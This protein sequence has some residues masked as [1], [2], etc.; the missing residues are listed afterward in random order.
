VA[1]G[2]QFPEAR[3]VRAWL[4]GGWHVALACV[5]GIAVRVLVVGWH[6]DAP[7]RAA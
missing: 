2:T 7:L 6:A 5:L 1:L 3:S 4:A